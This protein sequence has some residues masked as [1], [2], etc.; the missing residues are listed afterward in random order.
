MGNTWTCFARRR[1]P[2]WFDGPLGDTVRA[3]D[4][5]CP[6]GGLVC[7]EKQLQVRVGSSVTSV[8]HK[9]FLDFVTYEPCRSRSYLARPSLIRLSQSTVATEMVSLASFNR[10]LFIMLLGSLLAKLTCCCLSY[11]SLIFF[12]L[13][14][15]VMGSFSKARLLFVDD[16]LFWTGLSCTV[17]ASYF[18]SHG[19]VAYFLTRSL[20]LL[21]EGGYKNQME[22]SS[23]ILSFQNSIPLI[24]L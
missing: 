21:G 24:F 11:S 18:P 19:N 3:V 13:R 8:L 10:S 2:T 14:F 23:Q 7:L 17:Q 15:F 6:R 1:G 4:S 12:F 9:R 22:A 20:A 5:Q 16:G